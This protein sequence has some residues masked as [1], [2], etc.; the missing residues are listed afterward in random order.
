[1]VKVLFLEIFGQGSE[2]FFHA[3]AM[4]FGKMPKTMIFYLP[5]PAD[6]CAG[7]LLH[8]CLLNFAFG[9]DFVK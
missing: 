5:S 9:S 4:G 1:M 8:L 2:G 7:C 3:A 6:G